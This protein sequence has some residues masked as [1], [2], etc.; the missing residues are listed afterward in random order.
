MISYKAISQNRTAANPGAV[1]PVSLG[2]CTSVS[3]KAYD[4][5]EQK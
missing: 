4:N 3:L 5:I 2:F 1:Q